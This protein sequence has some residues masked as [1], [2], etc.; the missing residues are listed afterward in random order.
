MLALLHSH[1][2]PTTATVHNAINRTGRQAY[3]HGRFINARTCSM[4][5]SED[6]LRRDGVPEGLKRDR[7]AQRRVRVCV[8]I[9]HFLLVVI[10]ST[11]VKEGYR[12]TTELKPHRLRRRQRRHACC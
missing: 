7:G 10:R 6:Q 1:T 2:G 9:A 12:D 4:L 3:S 8:V 11:D 5:Q